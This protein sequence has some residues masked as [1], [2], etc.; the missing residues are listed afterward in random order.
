VTKKKRTKE[1]GWD[2]KTAEAL[3]VAMINRMIGLCPPTM[4]TAV[5]FR[6]EDGE[7]TAIGHCE[8]CVATL[9]HMAAEVIEDPRQPVMQPYPSV[10]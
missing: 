6:K 8:V 1:E 5:I 2:L 10:H 7:L 9:I 3:Y 4:K